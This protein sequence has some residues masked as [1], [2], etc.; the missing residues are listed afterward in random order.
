MGII[1]GDKQMPVLFSPVN[2]VYWVKDALYGW[3]YFVSITMN[4]PIS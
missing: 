1:I 2:A 4:K 3:A